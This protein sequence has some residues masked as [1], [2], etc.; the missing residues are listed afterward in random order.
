[1]TTP[2]APTHP[3]HDCVWG[4][5]RRAAV[6]RWLQTNQLHI[7]VDCFPLGVQLRCI[8]YIFRAPDGRKILI[9]VFFNKCTYTG[10]VAFRMHTRAHSPISPHS[11]SIRPAEH[12]ETRSCGVSAQ[13]PATKT[14]TARTRQLINFNRNIHKSLVFFD[15][16]CIYLLQLFMYFFTF[17][18]RYDI[19]KAVPIFLTKR[20][21]LRASPAARSVCAPPGIDSA[22][23]CVC[24]A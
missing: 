13:L 16:K 10:N 7:A 3:A 11:R 14:R 17:L 20:V 24:C 15:E 12:M 9:S 21:M 23:S 2:A 1:M 8:P 5:R 4:V 18:H 22:R 19:V 6:L